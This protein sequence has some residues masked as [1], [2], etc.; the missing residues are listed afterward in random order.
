MYIGICT[1]RMAFYFTMLYNLFI[2]MYYACI[3]VQV[4][5]YMYVSIYVYQY[6]P[7][8]LL[9]SFRNFICSGKSKRKSKRNIGEVFLPTT[10]TGAGNKKSCL[11]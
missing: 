10:N 4:F 3:Y 6:L 7:C 8:Y 1:T 11:K 9:L 2:F 5:K